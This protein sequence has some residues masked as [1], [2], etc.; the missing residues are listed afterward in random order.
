MP[1]VPEAELTTTPIHFQFN[2]VGYIEL[3]DG[4][5]YLV[6]RDNTRLRLKDVPPDSPVGLAS[7]QLIPSTDSTGI[8]QNLSIE[9]YSTDETD[10]EHGEECL[11]IGRVVQ[12]GK[13]GQFV[14]LKVSRPGEKTLK[15]GFRSPDPLMKMGTL[16]QV[17]AIRTG[18]CLH[19]QEAKPVV[20]GQKLSKTTPLPSSQPNKEPVQNGKQHQ[21]SQTTISKSPAETSLQNNNT[22]LEDSLVTAKNG[23]SSATSTTTNTEPV[24]RLSDKVP[25]AKPEAMPKVVSSKEQ[26]NVSVSAQAVSA[27]GASAESDRAQAALKEQASMDLATAKA[28]AALEAETQINDWELGK[29]KK[30]TA[31]SWE[32]EA[33]S[34]TTQR[35]ARVQVFS[36]RKKARVYQYPSTPDIQKPLPDA[37]LD[38]LIVRPLGAA[39]GIGASCFQIKIGSYEVVL[40]CGTR[41]KGYDPL[42]ALAHLENP[43]LLLI[44]HSHQDHLGAVPVFHS[45]WPGVRMICTPGTREIAHVMLTDCL[46]VQQLNEDSPQLFDETDLERTLFRLE[47]QAVGVEFEPLPGLKVRFINAGH[48]VGAACIYMRYGDRS[49]LYTGDYNTTSSRTTTGL[50]I[51]DL[52]QADIL[53]TESTYGADVHPA[54]KTQETALLEAIAEVVQ[55]G[56]NVLIPA[57]ALGRAQEIILAIRTSNLFHKLKIPVYVDG[58]V[59]AVTDVFRDNLDLLPAPVQNLV[60]QNGME[61][62]FDPTG[63]PPVIPISSPRERPLAM[64]KPSVIVASSGMLT[65]GPSVYY[66]AT[67]LE[68][69]NAAIFISGYTD[70][71]SP[72]RLLQNLETGDTVELDGK[73]IT[74]RAQIKRFSLSAHADKVG[75]G[76]VI[77]KVH[78]THLVLIHGG[79]TALHELARSGDLRSKHYIHIP[80]VGELVE[81]GQAPEHMSKAQITKIQLPQEFEVEV[82]AEVEGAWI[83]IPEEVVETDPRW[84]MLASSGILKA[85]WDG[86]HLKLSPVTQR[87]ISREK[88]VEDAIA[89]GED[90][91]A[92]CQF[93]QSGSCQCEDSSLFELYV[94]PA[95][96]CTEFHYSYGTEN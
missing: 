80:A 4:V 72:G 20:E 15:L 30:R 58:L 3:V 16:W 87:S 28:I 25:A 48:I 7:W 96:K 57:F 68:R 31:K 94:D 1:F 89:S 9:S 59:R 35:K 41:P 33:V 43:D 71:E 85:K 73:E 52:P 18:V 60:K 95:G 17:V 53:I 2:L 84:Q 77:N 64:A 50:A 46:K 67:L 23:D 13:R 37:E 29:L 70:E 12:L 26:V 39:L 83:R 34:K 24:N 65:G 56:G 76:Q 32:W 22:Q 88:A 93:F 74:V 10:V 36:N 61:P 27:L 11:L 75:L 19:I 40:D 91:C 54:R 79:T 81:Y 5:P 47:T 45:R 14:Q 44:S 92:V 51:A 66:A 55:A 62:F 38:H 8:I 49:L 6:C 78:P 90:C 63:T 42:P 69:E 82:E 21:T 86:F